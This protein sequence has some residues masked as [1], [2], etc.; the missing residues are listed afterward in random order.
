MS[1]GSKKIQVDMSMFL[2]V[3]RLV[4]A[5]EE[6]EL[7]FD[8][9]DICKRLERQIYAKFDAMEKRNIYTQSKIALTED[10]REQARQ[11]YLNLA[12][13]HGDFRYGKDFK[14]GSI[15]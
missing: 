15:T 5:L 8:T 3:F 7:D 6:Y 10:E 2:D 4:I 12:G 9:Q 13:I 14:D 11:K 1:S